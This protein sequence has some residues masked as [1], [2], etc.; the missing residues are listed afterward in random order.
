MDIP[1]EL[2]AICMHCL[3]EDRDH[4]YG[5][6]MDLL[7]DIQRY[8]HGEPV[9]V[10]QEPWYQL[11]WKWCRR[12]PVVSASVFSVVIAVIVLLISFSLARTIQSN[13][14]MAEGDR[15]R[16]IG[17]QAFG[18]AIGVLQELELLRA[19]LVSR[20]PD[21]KELRLERTLEGFEGT[22]LNNYEKAIVFYSQAAR[23]GQ[24]AERRAAMSSIYANRFR[25]A[26]MERDVKS[27][28]QLH[29]LLTGW[30][31]DQP[32]A[33]TAEAQLLLDQFADGVAGLEACRVTAPEGVSWTLIPL[34]DVDGALTEGEGVEP[35]EPGVYASLLPGAYILRVRS[36]KAES[37]M[38]FRLDHAEEKEIVLETPIAAPEGTV[39]VPAGRYW[40][41]GA[42]SRQ[43]RMHKAWLPAFFI[44]THEVTFDAYLTYW[45]T[46]S[47]AQRRADM[48]RVRFDPAIR[49]YQDAWDQRG[50]LIEPLQG[51]WPVVGLTAESAMR[52]C[53]W[54]SE[55]RGQTVRLP[56]AAEW[57]KAAR[58]GD[59][60]L[61][62]WGNGLVLDHA[63]IAENIDA[64]AKVGLFANPGWMVEDRSVYGVMDMGG[65]VREW[66][67]SR[68]GDGKGRFM[69][70]GS[71]ASVGQ[72]F[73]FCDY[74]S[75]TPVVPTD[76][77]FRIVIEIPEP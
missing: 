20:D 69:V 47:E 56:T 28:Q 55:T 26:R 23:F 7:A 52:Y 25:F 8:R 11:A 63:L 32:A 33:L 12:H 40:R 27:M 53:A 13:N 30:F 5:S 61:Y 1:R 67:G 77:G 73:L 15:Y 43:F 31:E 21:E 74:A 65:N 68:F 19:E 62:P 76:V 51:G 42:Q 3:R 46:L 10:Y 36:D 75:D 58:G 2:E 29:Q 41:G 4:R 34:K 66:T 44:G 6:V 22:F 16:I 35:T 59:G 45:K 17:D 18:E 64:K 14:L 37:I 38:S 60:R 72:R 70:K 57:E 71:S 24:S 9:L 50:N 54:L 39:F 48:A 49:A